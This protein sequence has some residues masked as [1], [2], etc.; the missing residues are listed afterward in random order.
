MMKVVSAVGDFEQKPEIEDRQPE[1][2]EAMWAFD[3]ID[4]AD[5]KV[6]DT[7]WMRNF[8]GDLRTL[9]VIGLWRAAGLKVEPR[10]DGM[11][12]AVQCPNRREHTDPEAFTG[13]VVYKRAGVY[14]FF[15][16]SRRRCRCGRF[17][18]REALLS[19]GAELVDT[20]CAGRYGADEVRCGPR[21][22]RGSGNA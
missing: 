7:A 5:L 14:P 8:K 3:V 22:A 12:Y 16:C 21:D 1:S 17:S 15:H 13:T 20:N 11:S 9:D 19:F 2:E 10:K 4:P 18:T 6:R